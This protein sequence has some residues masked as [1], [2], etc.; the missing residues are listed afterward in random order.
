LHIRDDLVIHHVLG[1]QTERIGKSND[2]L[3]PP[4]RESTPSGPQH[5][6][7]RRSAVWTGCVGWKRGRALRESGATRCKRDF[8]A[9]RGETPGVRS[10]GHR[11]KNTV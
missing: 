1:G 5:D 10:Y 3:A 7:A 4:L 2:L 9:Q 8:N 6:V 11:G